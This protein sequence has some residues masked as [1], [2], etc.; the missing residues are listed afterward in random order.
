MKRLFEQTSH[1]LNAANRDSALF[2]CL[3]IPNDEVRLVVVDCLYFV[4][5]DEIEYDELDPLLRAMNPQNIG[6]GKNE[7]ILSAIFNVLSRLISDKSR[8]TSKLTNLF[9]TRF[10][11]TAIE[12]ALNILAK[13]QERHV[14]DFQEESEEYT[15]SLN[16]VNFLK[17]I[18]KD[19]KT[20]GFLDNRGHLLQQ[21][22]LLE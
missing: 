1:K 16:I 12:L 8:E 21:I 4:P 2:R 14:E 20:K 6:T 18:S 3:D 17:H 11:S 22:L 5:L 13:N 7:L 10:G 9:K 15:L 19:E